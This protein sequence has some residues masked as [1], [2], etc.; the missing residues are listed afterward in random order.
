MTRIAYHASH[1]QFSPSELLHLAVAAEQAGFQAIH[2]SDH[3]RPWNTHQGHSG[4]SLAW[5]GA[6]MQATS[7]PFGLV[8]APGYRYHPA[9]LAQAFATLESLFPKRFWAA[10]GSGEAINESIIGES[11]PAKAERNQ[12]LL[13]S[14]ESIYKM[15]RGKTVNIDSFI[16]L[17]DAKIYSLPINAPQ[18]I[19]AAVTKETAKWMGKWADGLI[20]VNKER[21]ELEALVDAFHQG[22]GRGK[23][24]YIKVQLSYAETEEMALNGAMEQWKTNVLDSKLLA[25]LPT[26]ADLETAARGVGPE[27]IRAAVRISASLEQHHKWISEYI[28]LGFHTVI[29]HNVNRWQ[30]QFIH[31][32]GQIIPDINDPSS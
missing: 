29:L 14:Y 4:F 28:D 15:L 10:L 24:L 8:C 19:G 23:P 22:G 6:A 21:T 26:I 12:R 32:F 16:K 9:V 27:E 17:R 3:I 18:L 20:T 31:D 1:E 25:N 13:E 7:L 11:W 2:S 30:E 5:L